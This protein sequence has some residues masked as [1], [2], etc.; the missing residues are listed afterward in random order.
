MRPGMP[1]VS[2]H[3]LRVQPQTHDLLAASHGRGL[4]ILD[5][6]AP[7][8]G[9]RGARASSKPTF[10]PVR[11]PI[12][13]YYWWKSAYPTGDDLCCGPPGTFAALDPP[14]GAWISYYLPAKLPSSPM[15]RIEDSQSRLVREVAGTNVPG[16]N[17]VAWNLTDS[18]PVPWQDTGDWN[19]GPEDG[20]PVVPGDYRA[21]LSA[22]GASLEERFTVHADPRASWSQ[23][24]YV[25][26]YTFLKALDDELSQID[27]ALNRL[28]EAKRHATPARRRAIESV[29][30][31][32][33]SGVRN[34]EDDL[35]MP[36]RVRE[37]VTILQGTVALSQGPPLPP[38]EREA[39]AITA[40]FEQA[41]RAYQSLMEDLP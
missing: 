27:G 34:P 32:F 41:M 33:T 18:P 39:A 7:I 20:T 16:I 35:W 29:Y 10:F 40:Q 22:G 2:I 38:H 19:R 30:R 37:R 31:Q 24:D 12:A 8:E 1:P 26:R 5:D 25:A 11:D 23:N 9:L 13:W 3:D 14:Y 28:D 15:I 4:F 21:T 36:D 17:R 6:L